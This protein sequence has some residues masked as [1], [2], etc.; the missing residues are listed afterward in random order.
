MKRLPKILGAITA[1]ALAT[2]ACLSLGQS[3]SLPNLSGQP[4]V[5]VVAFPSAQLPLP[6]ASNQAATQDTLVKLYAAVNPGVVSILVVTP[7]GEATAS[8]F[9]VDDSGHIVT[10]YHVVEGASSLE[11]GFVTG[12]KVHGQVVG[13]DLDSDIAVVQVKAP[14][15]ELH[16]LV[17]GD[18][19][20]VQVGQTVV[21]I[22]NPFRLNGTMTVGIVSGLGRTVQSLHSTSDG[23]SFSAADVI[24]TDAAINPGNSGGPLLDLNGQVIGVNESIRTTTF[25]T[26]GQPVNSGIGFA[27]SAN[28]IKRVLPDLITHGKYDYPYLGITSQNDLTLAEQ[29][30]LGLSQSTGVYITGVVPG[31]PADKAGLRAGSRNSSIDN[32]KAGGDL[33]TGVDGK[34]VRTYNDLIGYLVENKSPGDRV[35]LTVLRDGKQTPV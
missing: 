32:L 33:I 34:P 27:I 35:T 16:P 29:E 4:N 2:L 25:S 28:M 20:Q 14:A 24:Q 30:A 31:G 10:N 3:P 26:Q 17:L 5:T 7:D 9:V 8:G 13:A 19:S 6:P 22:G 21:A 18:S 11:I 23:G 12:L 1:L 15:E